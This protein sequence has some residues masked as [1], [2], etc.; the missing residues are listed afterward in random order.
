MALL[1]SAVCMSGLVMALVI[2]RSSSASLMGPWGPINALRPCVQDTNVE[3]SG[4]TEI[5]LGSLILQRFEDK[6][7]TRATDYH[8]LT[9]PSQKWS[10]KEERVAIKD[11]FNQNGPNFE[12]Q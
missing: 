11:V 10:R 5:L 12:S 2:F 8:Q 3:Q 4:R 6:K 9:S 7:F 1:S